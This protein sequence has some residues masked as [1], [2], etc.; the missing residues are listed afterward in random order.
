MLELNF[1]VGLVMLW[2]RG[3]I[4][5]MFFLVGFAFHGVYECSS[6]MATA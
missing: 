3:S 1:V 6:F 2:D 4:V 5:S